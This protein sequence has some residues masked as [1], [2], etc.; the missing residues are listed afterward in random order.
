MKNLILASTSPRR[1]ELLK[2]L[3]L[4]FKV[5]SPSADE[6]PK[7][8]EKPAALVAR[9]ALEKAQSAARMLKVGQKNI[10]LIIAADTI[11]VEPKGK[12]ILGKPRSRNEAAKMLRSIQA[13][14]HTVLTGYCSLEINPI[15]S[16]GYAHSHV[17]VVKSRVTM[18]A[19][20]APQIRAYVATGEPMDKA[21]SYA[22]QGRG[23]ALIEKI[24]GSYANVVGLPV[25]QVIRDLEEYF[26]VRVLG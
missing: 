7:K 4:Q 11:V 18:R 16:D 10:T 12:K 26:E 19:L 17:R 1:I 14:T 21:G 3:G 25:C 22:A 13:A 23:M 24:D 9:L 5:I 20:S 6:T 15:E 8:N 2:Q